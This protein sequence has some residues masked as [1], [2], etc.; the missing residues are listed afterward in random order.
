MKP[1]EKI[2]ELIRNADVT[3]DPGAQT[4]TLNRPSVVGPRLDPEARLLTSPVANE[5]AQMAM[6][7]GTRSFC[8]APTMMQ[9]LFPLGEVRLLT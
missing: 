9:F 8:V 4:G 2:R 1:E 6:G 5:L 3:A 7:L